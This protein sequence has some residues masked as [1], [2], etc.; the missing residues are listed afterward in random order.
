MIGAE[1]GYHYAGSPLVAAETGDAPPY[2]FIDYTPST[3]PG[4]RLPHVWLDDGRA[5]QD[6]IGDGYTLLR[7]GGSQRDTSALAR[8]VRARSARRSR[9]SI[10]RDRRARDI[11]GHDLMLVRP[12]LHV[13][14]RGNAAP[15]RSGTGS[16][17]WR[18][19]IG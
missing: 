4:V 13:V 5:V 11:Y 16:P 10:C 15:E 7:L 17:P 1:L 18:P 9:R 19:G 2:D 8:G 3:L 6:C 14:W 12:D